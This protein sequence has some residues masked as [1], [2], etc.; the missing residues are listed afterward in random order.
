[1]LFISDEVMTGFGR[2][3]K[4]WG[5][6]HWGVTPDIIATAKGIT[7]GYTPLSAVVAK[8][9]IWQP[10]ID[11]NSP[12]KAGHTLNANAVSCAGAL[13]TINYTQEH[14][15]VHRSAQMGEYMLQ[16]MKDVLLPHPSVGDVRGKGLMVGF[17]QVKDKET[18]EPFDSGLKV[19][20]QL[21]DEAFKRG[22]ITYPCS[23]TVDGYAGDMTLLA[24]PLIITREQI[25]DVVSILDEALT[26]VEEKLL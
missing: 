6:E 12:F 16:K 22:L 11:N 19:S 26:V 15:L 3:G 24:P 5:I 20:Q 17:E 4:M 25:D 9:E 21:E 2:T 18:K 7:S 23:G 10:L 8:N 13:A 1:V 14:N